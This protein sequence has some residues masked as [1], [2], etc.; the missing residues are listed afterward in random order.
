MRSGK[1]GSDKMLRFLVDEEAILNEKIKRGYPNTK[2][3]GDKVV[4]KSIRDAS[5]YDYD[6][7]TDDGEILVVK[8][9]E[10]E[11]IKIRRH[12]Y[13]PTGTEVTLLTKNLITGDVKVRFPSGLMQVI[14]LEQLGEMDVEGNRLD[15]IV[16]VINKYYNKKDGTY[17]LPNDLLH[18]LIYYAYNGGEENRRI[19]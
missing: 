2:R 6:V 10:L 8:D 17:T 13:I 11:K 4:I 15:Q 19:F 18:E 16:Q 5:Q 3:V 7:E 9:E 1:K 12:Y 14:K